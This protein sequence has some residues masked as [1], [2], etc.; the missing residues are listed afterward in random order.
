MFYENDKKQTFFNKGEAYEFAYL[1]IVLQTCQHNPSVK[2]KTDIKAFI[3]SA[4]LACPKSKDRLDQTF[5]EH[6]YNSVTNNPFYTPSSRSL[7]D[8]NF[9]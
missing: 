5:Y 1:I 4:N 8:E 2:Q 9:N 7:I 3:E 6:I